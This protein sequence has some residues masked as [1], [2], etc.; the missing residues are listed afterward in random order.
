MSNSMLKTRWYVFKQ[1]KR[2]FY[3]LICFALLFL[4]SVFAEFIA[5]DKPLFI[6]K[7]SKMYFPVF[8]NSVE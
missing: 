2:A 1:N 5:N 6:Y 4:I 3:S 7:D 8:V